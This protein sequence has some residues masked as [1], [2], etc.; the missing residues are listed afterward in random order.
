MRQR[1]LDADAVSAHGSMGSRELKELGAQ[2]L[3]VQAAGRAGDGLL[4]VVQCAQEPVAERDRDGGERQELLLF[5]RG[6]DCEHGIG[7]ADEP[8]VST[9]RRNECAGARDAHD[10]R[11]VRAEPRCR[12]EDGPTLDDQQP[13]GRDVLPGERGARLEDGSRA[14]TKHADE[15]M[16]LVE[17]K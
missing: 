11:A 9:G 15:R 10:G 17:R 4:P 2:A 8:L 5:C 14:A 1:Q 13:R 7:E 3:R 12:E 16:P 6:H